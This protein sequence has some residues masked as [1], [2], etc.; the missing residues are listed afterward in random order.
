MIPTLEERVAELERRVNRMEPHVSRTIPLG[1]LAQTEEEIQDRTKKFSEIVKKAMEN[2]RKNAVPVDRSNQQLVSGK[3]VP[4]DRSHEELKPNG[5][6]KD[7]VVLSPEER[8]KGFV[9][10]VRNK[11][12]HVGTPK[13]EYPLRDLTPEEQARWKNVGY[14]KFEDYGDLASPARGRFYTQEQMDKIGNG[15]GTVTTMGTAMAETYARAPKFYGG[16]FC[17][18]CNRHLPVNEFVWA[19]IEERVG[20]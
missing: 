20:S 16:T 8:A 6:Q 12:K 11:Y 15:C 18:G 10:P 13:P 2:I 1:P 9:R 7:Y 17:C 14:V 4:A 3:P 5:Q 19:G